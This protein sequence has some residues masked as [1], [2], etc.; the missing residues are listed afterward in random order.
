MSQCDREGLIGVDSR[1]TPEDDGNLVFLT[2]QSN[3]FTPEDDGDLVVLI[4]QPNIFTP[5]DDGDLVVLINQPNI[6]TPLPLYPFVNI[7]K[8]FNK[9]TKVF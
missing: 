1:A 6:F 2:Y 3:I 4:N 9:N 8:Y 7:C 5:E